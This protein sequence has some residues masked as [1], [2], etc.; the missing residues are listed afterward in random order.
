[1]TRALCDR[2]YRRLFLAQVAA[3]LGSGLLTV[4]L[5]LLAHDLAGERASGV[6]GAVLAAKMVAYVVVAPVAAALTEQLPR[7]RVMVG[8][9]LVRLAV[10]AAFPFVTSAWQVLVLVLVF[11]LQAASATFTPAF[12]AVIPAVLPDEDDH[13]AALSLSRL[14]YDLEAIVS[15]VLA[16]ALL[17][18]LEANQLF[19]GT[20]LGCV[21]SALLVA[22]S[23]LPRLAPD[24]GQDAPGPPWG[25]RARAG[26]RLFVSTP[27]LRP[28]LALNMAVAAAGGF[29]LVETIVVMRFQLG[30]PESQVA[31]FLAVTGAGSMA[32]ALLLPQ[33]LARQGERLPMLAG[34]AV[35]AAAPA[36]AALVLALA[37]G[38]V[39]QA[40]LVALL[41]FLV[42]LGWSAAE[43]PA[44]RLLRRHVEPSRLWPSPTV[45]E[46]A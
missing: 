46:S 2:T 33:L 6:L 36:L 31:V 42:G 40:A 35:L 5:G 16:A 34:G 41:W 12:Q 21:G 8:A 44:G 24:A 45:Q 32:G 17:L 29:V 20:A 26:G 27:G 39:G 37:P 3:L 4:A 1:M 18:V 30:L 38:G 9:D 28:V 25:E 19:V 22:G 14:A 11:V 15:P 7:R 43:T 23:S 10:A 13:A